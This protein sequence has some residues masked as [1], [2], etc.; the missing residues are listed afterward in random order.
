MR[1][2]VARVVRPAGDTPA[3]ATTV[4]ANSSNGTTIAKRPCVT[5]LRCT[6]TRPPRWWGTTPTAGC[7]RGHRRD[8]PGRGR[9]R[10]GGGLH[11]GTGERDAMIHLKTEAELAKMRAPGLVVH[12]AP[13]RCARR[14]RPRGEHARS[15]RD[16]REDDCRSGC[17]LKL[18][19]LPRRVDKPRIRGDLRVG[20][21]TRSCTAFRGPTTSCTRATSSRSTAARS[22]TAGTAMPR[23]RSASADR[24]RRPADA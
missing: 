19:G 22:S 18:Q 1:P 11:F 17:H 4:A 12:A 14:H 6:P 3:R 8:R 7:F 21:I 16:R 24:S 9:D 23:S 2:R 5:D 10:P 15:R 13:K 20:S